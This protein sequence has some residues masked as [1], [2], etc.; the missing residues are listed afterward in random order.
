M[1]A[2][3]T[4]GFYTDN[5]AQ[6]DPTNGERRWETIAAAQ[7][8][9]AVECQD[10]H[11][12]HGNG[13]AERYAR[14]G[15]N[16]NGYWGNVG[17][18]QLVSWGQNPAANTYTLY[19]GNYLNWY[20]GPTAFQTRLQVVQD[21]ATDLLDS[22]NGVNVGLI[23]FNDVVDGDPIRSEGGRV[24]HAMEAI[25]TARAPMQATINALT[26]ETYTPLSETLYEAALYYSGGPV[27]FRQPR[28]RRRLARAR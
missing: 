21:V 6:Y 17:D 22:V 4:G 15:A 28:Q 16:T 23:Y 20:Y 9:R 19:S 5:M 11:G 14:N 27:S 7:K 26:P 1:T 25:A 24:Q 8:T 12:T 3:T 18:T 13:G 2:F 10:D